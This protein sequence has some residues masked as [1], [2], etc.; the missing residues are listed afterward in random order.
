MSILIRDETMATELASA[1]GPQELRTSDGRLLGRF[2]PAASD[3][4][5]PEFGVKYSELLQEIN[6]P[7]TKW[8]TP[9]EV[10]TRLREIDRCSP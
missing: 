6:D 4:V 7:N 5:F 10:M 3:G 9:D 2:I 1:D 8:H